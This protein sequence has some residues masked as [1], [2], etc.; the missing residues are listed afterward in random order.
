M[1]GIA[2]GGALLAVIIF[3]LVGFFC[4]RRA[5]IRAMRIREEENMSLE[6]IS[7]TIVTLD[8]PAVPSPI[9]GSPRRERVSSAYNS[10]ANPH[11]LWTNGC[12]TG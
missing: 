8:S 4:R 9:A 7:Y 3:G 12:S 11:H 2:V 10:F 5:S 1:V 6:D